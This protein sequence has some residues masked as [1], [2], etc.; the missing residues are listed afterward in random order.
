MDL[1][2]DSYRDL[3][4]SHI[5]RSCSEVGWGHLVEHLHQ[6]SSQTSCLLPNRI[7]IIPLVTVN[8]G[9]FCWQASQILQL[10]GLR[11]RLLARLFLVR[12][13]GLKIDFKNSKPANFTL[14]G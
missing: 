11:L 12:L 8:L 6:V 14:K 5:C 4:E 7:P 1:E 13:K 3:W 2:F 9:L 10:F